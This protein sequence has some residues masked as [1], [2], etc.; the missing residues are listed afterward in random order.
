MTSEHR[1]CRAVRVEAERSGGLPA[2]R[3]LRPGRRRFCLESLE[4]RQL[5]T[6]VPFGPQQIIDGLDADGPDRV[7][8]ADIDGDGDADALVVS[9]RDNRVAWFENLGAG[10]FSQRLIGTDAIE[11]RD[12]LAVDLDG[13]Q[14]LDVVVA[15]YG[16]DRVQWYQNLDGLG[17]FDTAQ[18]VA[19]QTD[20]VRTLDA[21]DLDGDG[22]VDLVAGSWIN[23]EVTWYRNDGQGNF[24][25]PQ[26]I[27]ASPEG[28]RSVKIG[29]LND[30]DLP[31]IAVA[32]RFDDTLAW[33]PNQGNGTFG[34]AQVL[35]FSGDGPESIELADVDSDGD[36]D[37]F[38]AL[39][40]DNKLAWFEN[41]DSQ[42]TFGTQ[43]DLS[44]TAERGQSVTLA[45]VDGDGDLDLIGASYFYLDNENKV[46]WFPNLDGLGT[47]GGERIISLDAPGVE[48]VAVADVDQDGFLDVL[49][50]S[51]IDNN[52]SWF[53][54]RD[55]LGNFDRQRDILSDAGGALSAALA[56]LDGDGDLDVVAAGY[57]DN[58]VAWYENLDGEGTFSPQRVVTNEA[59]RVQSV[60][61]ADLDGDG[62]EDLLSAS[63]DDGKIAW[64]PNVDGKGTFA[65][66][67][68]V[69]NRLSGATA[70][71]AADLDG[72][73][74]LDVAA[75]SYSQGIVAWF[76][77]LDGDGN[78]GA[79]QILTR[80][81]IGAEWL[82]A[83]DL[84]G[85]GHLDLI[86]AAYGN[87]NTNGDG[88]LLWFQN[89]DGEGAF[90]SA[91]SIARGGG[92]TTVEA[93]DLDG[94]GDLDL[95]ST[96]YEDGTL[97]WIENT[98]QATFGPA[99]EIA[100]GLSRLEALDL[101]DIDGNG[102]QDLLL[103]GEF[104]LV[105]FERLPDGSFEG[106][107]IVAST[108]LVGQAFDVVAGD[109]NG[110]DRPDIVSAT[111]YDSKIALYLNQSGSGD[112][113]GDGFVDAADIDLLCQAI[114]L[115][116][117][118]A[119][120]D[121]NRDGALDSLD[122]DELIEQVLQT[123]YGD[124]NLDGLFD[125]RDLVAIFQTGQYEDG[126]DD[127]SS[128]ATGDW[129]CDGDFGTGD[130]VLAFQ[131]GTYTTG[132]EPLGEPDWAL[133]AAAVAADR[134]QPWTAQRSPRR[135]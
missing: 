103:G 8:A 12:V 77:N 49:A 105:W 45:D 3:S 23:D 59:Q 94:D 134:T 15:A 17:N 108:Q 90:S 34:T 18:S 7:V 31:D 44:V 69:T 51:V 58:E 133:L 74:D 24:G 120:F 104:F 87:Y 40:F 73:G 97:V 38:V 50:A 119:V 1:S 115:S 43:Q 109:I 76:E 71:H 84:D 81:A 67:R 113:D 19:N 93:L 63:F 37:L 5:L 82:T 55:G 56:D 89:T 124:A 29:D 101:A 96:R 118:E 64:Y 47:F 129:D 42:G 16:A 57:W 125:S 128:W 14:D 61:T 78:F 75:A 46:V 2:G 85:D 10:Q 60:R 116:A 9:Y 114:R 112:F 72:D 33:F 107:T 70:V 65:S 100:E 79:I 62:N 83:A 122:L 52:V 91:R 21:A 117:T 110:D 127:N 132:A 39:Y 36:L 41:T 53:R 13:D 28:P 106:H 4:S 66:Q 32:Y 30:D 131:R 48:H 130:L 6:A 22:H 135:S 88:E 123:S 102:T 99:Q 11:A 95:V 111:F 54:N 121:L 35:N 98:G 80:R 92:P 126:I 25:L 86:A 27:S 20:G 68:L 26:L